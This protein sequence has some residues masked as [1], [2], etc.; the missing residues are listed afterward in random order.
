VNADISVY[1]NQIIDLVNACV[2]ALV[3]I[4]AVV[5]LSDTDKIQ[6]IAQVCATILLDIQASISVFVAIVDIVTA[7]INLDVALNAWLVQLNVCIT[8]FLF[9]LAPL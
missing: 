7:V 3:S 8:G 5:D 4:G 2:T 1:I 9:I 6:A